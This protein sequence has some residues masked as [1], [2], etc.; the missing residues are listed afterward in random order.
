MMKNKINKTIFEII[1]V[2]IALI[3]FGIPLF[4][5][6]V[7]SAKDRVEAAQMSI[8]LPETNVFWENYKTV[9]TVNDGMVMRAFFN[10]T[11]ITVISIIG[12]V[13]FASMA[14]FV[15]QRRS[16][17]LM[18]VFG[19]LIFAGLIMPPAVVPTIWILNK[20][21]LFKTKLGLIFVEI[22]LQLP[23]AIIIYRGFISTIPKEID[24][25]ATIDGCGTFRMFFSIIFPLLKPVTSTI[26]VLSSVII[27]NDFTN[28]LYFLPGSENITIQLSLYNF[29]SMYLTEWNLLFAG[30]ILISIPPLILFIFFNKKLVAGITAGSV[31]G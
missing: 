1:S 30:I 22:A 20:L 10:S 9:L 5:V 13:V 27:F 21:F 6:L 7:N 2:I 23:F 18:L 11:L 28:P 25:A 12:L 14:S 19:F 16:T 24:Q 31:K 15:M 4:F 26:V 17:K 29:M 8:S 3:I